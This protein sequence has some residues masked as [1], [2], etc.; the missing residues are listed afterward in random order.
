ML[1]SRVFA[2]KIVD[3][4]EQSAFQAVVRAIT[5]D[6]ATEGKRDHIWGDWV[7]CPV[8][9]PYANE[10]QLRHRSLETL[11]VCMMEGGLIMTV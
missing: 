7:V 11:H 1:K 2:V 9:Q 5:V 10:A 4:Q 3:A 6:S 8:M